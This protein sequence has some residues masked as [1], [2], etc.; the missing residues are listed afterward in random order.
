MM[1][2]A[3]QSARTEMMKLRGVQ[4]MVSKGSFAAAHDGVL[5]RL[6]RPGQRL[7]TI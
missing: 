6:G 7:I 1:T 3:Q 4:P 5:G 2:P